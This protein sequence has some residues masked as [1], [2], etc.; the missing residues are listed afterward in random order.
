MSANLKKVLAAAMTR[1]GFKTQTA[2]AEASGVTLDVVHKLCA[3][4][5]TSTSVSNALALS[6]VL[7]ID[8]LLFDAQARQNRAA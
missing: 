7:D 5:R 3:G 4:T 8:P 2:L 6:R 1:K